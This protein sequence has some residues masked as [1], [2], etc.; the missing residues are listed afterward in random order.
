VKFISPA[1]ITC[2]LPLPQHM[3]TASSSNCHVSMQTAAILLP[4]DFRSLCY[5]PPPSSQSR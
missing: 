3:C 1:A 5:L 2:L 4:E